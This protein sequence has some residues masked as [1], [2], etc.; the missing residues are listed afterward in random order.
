MLKSLLRVLFRVQEFMRGGEALDDLISD[1]REHTEREALLEVVESSSSL[2]QPE[3]G[4]SADWHSTPGQV[5][6]MYSILALRMIV[7]QW[8]VLL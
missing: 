2:T 3:S 8:N 1:V 6:W 4:T 7:T 5:D